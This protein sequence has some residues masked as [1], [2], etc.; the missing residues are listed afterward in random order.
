[1][2]EAA[3]RGLLIGGGG[4][5]PPVRGAVCR[6]AVCR[7]VYSAALI[8]AGSLAIGLHTGPVTVEMEFDVVLRGYDRA[9]VEAAV[10]LVAAAL[11]SDSAEQRA[12]ARQELRDLRFSL[13]LRGYDR[14]QVD[15][16][17]RKASSQLA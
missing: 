11:G 6:A 14:A 16:F 1:V 3:G 7:A 5:A 8:P 13:R 12:A 2:P 17:I 15:S 10:Q 4:A 9:E